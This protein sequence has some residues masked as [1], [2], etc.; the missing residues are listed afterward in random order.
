MKVTIRGPRRKELELQGDWHVK[1]LLKRL[2]LN[3]ENF[4]V[5]QGQRLLTR[6]A[7]VKNDESIEI[8][9]AISGGA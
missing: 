1:D 9:S 5:I 6:D 3:P 8:L 7:L 2:D 4:I